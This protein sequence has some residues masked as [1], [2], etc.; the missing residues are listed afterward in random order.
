MRDFP[1]YETSILDQH[2][3]DNSKFEVPH[4]LPLPQ[5]PFY[6]FF[7]FLQIFFTVIQID[8]ILE[9]LN[10]ENSR[11]TLVRN[12]SG[13]ERKRLSIGIELVTNPPIMFFDE[14]TSGLDSVA[15]LQIMTHLRRLA[16]GGRMIVCVVHQPSSKLMRLFD[17]VLV[18]AGG[19]VLYSGLQEEM[20]ERFEEFG[21]QCPQY[22]NPADFGK[23]F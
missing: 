15:S 19:E 13:G 23:Q 1:S 3:V 16:Q 4:K 17:N 20:I 11:K 8:A 14:P 7:S 2:T 9:L 5:F 22:Y 6:L 21:F 12:L 18:M 10:L